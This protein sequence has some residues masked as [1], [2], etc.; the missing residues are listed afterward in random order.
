MSFGLASAG[1]GIRISSFSIF[2]I[3]SLATFGAFTITK[4]FNKPQYLA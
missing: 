2:L 4:E 3:L 1:K